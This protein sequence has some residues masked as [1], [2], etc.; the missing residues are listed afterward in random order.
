MVDEPKIHAVCK[1][2]GRKLSAD[3]RGTGY[4]STCMIEQAE[5]YV[6]E[7]QERPPIKREKKSRT[8]LIVQLTIILAGL[9][10]MALQTPRFI[11]ALKKEGQP[12]RQGTYAT[13]VQ[14]DQCIKNL[15]HISRL[16]QEGKA[17]NNDIVC[18]VS[19][20][21]YEIIVTGGDVV[22]RCPNPELHGMKIIQ[23]SKKHPVPEISK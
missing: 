2:C 7:R 8:R 11:D 17:Q 22:V 15:W 13:D 20:K 10:I 4:C 9:T 19:K 1:G 21:P 6:P 5:Q 3:E 14:T 12:L 16:L 23:V 18:P